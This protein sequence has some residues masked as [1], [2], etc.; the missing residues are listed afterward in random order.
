M[1]ERRAPFPPHLLQGRHGKHFTCP[2]GFI[3]RGG[4]G[5][6]SA[7]ALPGAG[8]STAGLS[9]EWLHHLTRLG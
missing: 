8:D 9:V 4:S 3:T 1:K 6:S 7:S 2:P 5:A